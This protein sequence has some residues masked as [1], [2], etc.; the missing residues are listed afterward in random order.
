VA[1]PL[2]GAYPA[3]AEDV[4]S[5]IVRLEHVL[6]E[7]TMQSAQPLI[8]V[9]APLGIDNRGHSGGRVAHQVR[10]APEVLVEDLA[11]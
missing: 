6:D 10:A 8:G 9:D 5:V 7:H 2:P 11:E 1:Q 3:V 4:V